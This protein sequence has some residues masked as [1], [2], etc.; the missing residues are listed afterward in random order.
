MKTL[1]QQMVALA[2]AVKKTR[3]LHLH[4]HKQT[5]LFPR[6]NLFSQIEAR[7]LLALKSSPLGLSSQIKMLRQS[8]GNS[9]LIPKIIEEM[10]RQAEV[11]KLFKFPS[12]KTSKYH[13]KFQLISK[14]NEVCKLLDQLRMVTQQI[15]LCCNSPK[16][17]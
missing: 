6:F 14:L 17:T 12:P 11:C 7:A 2:A 4:R 5:S 13:G 9:S 15:W 8:R 3:L 1:I 16:Q 10:L